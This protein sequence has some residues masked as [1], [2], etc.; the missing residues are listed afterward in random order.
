MKKLTR[1]N[2][3]LDPIFDEEKASANMPTFRRLYRVCLGNAL[4]KTP[5][6]A[7]DLVQVG[8]KLR[9]EDADVPLEDAEFALLKDAV[10]RNSQSMVAQL[11]GQL[12]LRLR[13]DENHKG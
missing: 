4:A 13:E 7:V 2:D 8:L 9:L 5:D 3:K 6:E 1:L 12:I 11:Q 10:T